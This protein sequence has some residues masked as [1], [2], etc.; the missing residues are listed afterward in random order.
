[1]GAE[2]KRL[3]EARPDTQTR[4]GLDILWEGRFRNVLLESGEGE[5]KKGRGDEEKEKETKRF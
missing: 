5:G 1:L 3:E 2:S 4:P